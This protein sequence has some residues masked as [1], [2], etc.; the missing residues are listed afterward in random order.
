MKTTKRLLSCLLVLAM[1]FALAIPAFADGSKKIVITNTEYGTKYTLY[2]LFNVETATVKDAAGED[3]TIYSYTINPSGTLTADSLNAMTNAPFK[4][5]AGHVVEDTSFK[6]STL[7]AWLEVNKE[8]A[9]KLE[10]KESEGKNVEFTVATD[11]YYFIVRNANGLATPLK[12][13]ADTLN[14]DTLTVMDKNTDNTTDPEHPDGKDRFKTGPNGAEYVTTADQGNEVTFTVTFTTKNWGKNPLYGQPGNENAPEIAPITKYVVTDTPVGMTIKT[15]NVTV[16]VDGQA[17]A[18]TAFTV[19]PPTAPSKDVVV[20]IPWNTSIAPADPTYKQGA[21]VEITYTGTLDDENATNQ[22]LIQP[23]VGEQ[24]GTEKGDDTPV[25]IDTADI[26]ILKTDAADNSKLGNA[27][28]VLT[29]DG[30]SGKTLYYVQ[31]NDGAV[32][33][34]ED[35]S[36]ATE[37]TTGNDNTNTETFGRASFKG[38]KAGIYKLVEKTAPTG[39]NGLAAP[40]VL[41]VES[42]G[43]KG[44]EFALIV[45]DA[46]GQTLTDNQVTVENERGATLPSTGGIGTTMFYVIG[47]ILVAAA[48]VVLV[49]KKRMGAEQ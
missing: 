12:F 25:Y 10:T 43:K 47:G 9:Q 41:K 40:V 31:G 5:E 15:N 46:T 24:K 14:G 18:D 44:A 4:V 26:N 13:N 21:V 6:D 2:K 34:T 28:F 3:K 16:K 1:M 45:E 33:W 20:S 37:M 35:E 7:S 27:V 39:Y 48:V 8:L 17:I 30:D 23:Y 49:S 22:A 32:T 38:L 19:T 42:N 29:K 36:A 11:G